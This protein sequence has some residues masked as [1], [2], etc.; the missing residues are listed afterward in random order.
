MI[1]VSGVVNLLITQIWRK[2]KK[3]AS[4]FFNFLHMVCNLALPSQNIYPFS[5]WCAVPNRIKINSLDVCLSTLIHLF[6]PCRH[7]QD[8]VGVV[9]LGYLG[10]YE[11]VPQEL[12]R[13]DAPVGVAA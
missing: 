11:G 6:P 9:V 5:S 2:Q 4:H 10:R 13:G 7:L 1:S 3:N 8:W 12:H